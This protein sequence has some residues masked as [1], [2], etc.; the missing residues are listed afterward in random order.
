M[1]KNVIRRLGWI[2]MAT[3]ASVALAESHKLRVNDP[4]LAKSL[5][6]QGGR[7]VADYGSFQ[8][9][10]SDIVPPG[11]TG[12]QG[13]QLADDLNLI[14]L[15]A[16]VL[17]TRK[18]EIQASRR[19]V[20]PFSGKRLH[21]V[22]FAGPIRPEWVEALE[23][24]GV[25][26]ISYIPQDAYLIYGNAAALGRMQ[27][28]ARATSFVQWEGAY[29]PEYRIHPRAR[30][31]DRNRG[32]RNSGTDRFA[33][34]LVDDPDANPATLALIDRLKL[35]PVENQF[36][37]LR[38]LNVIV[39]L[40][41]EQLD[42]IAAQPEVVSIQP[43]L[44]RMKSDERQDQILAGNLSGGA[45]TGPGY[46]SWLASKG[47]TQEQFEESGFVVDLTDSGIDNGTN[48][49]GHFGLYK[50]GDPAEWSRIAYNRL[51]GS[52]NGG[53]TLQGCDGHGNLNAHIVGGYSAFTG[54]PFADSAGFD[55]GL[56][57]C[58]FVKIGSS[59]VFDPD[60]FTFPNYANL[61]SDAYHDGARVSANSWGAWYS[62][63]AYDIDA[64]RYD[65]LVRDA[66]PTN[67]T[68]AT[69]G[70]QQMVIVFAAGNQGPGAQT[71]QSPG[72][73]KNV[74]TVG[75]SESVRSLTPANGGN[76]SAGNDGCNTADSLADNA[77]DLA[78]YSG[79][80]PCSDGRMKPDIV[81]PGTHITGGVAQTSPPATNGTGSAIPC[82][83]ASE[84]ATLPG[85]GRCGTPAAGNTNNFFPLGQQFY[86]VSSGTSHATPAVAGVC[87]LVRQYFINHGLTPPSPAITKACLINSARY[88]NGANANDSLWSPSQGMGA[89]NLGTAFD[90]VPRIL[91][92]QVSGE[93]FTATGQTNLIT[94]TITD[95]TKPFRVT[96]AWTDAPG[97]TSGNAY[98]NDLDLTVTVGGNTYKGNVFAGAFTVAG[99]VY[100]K[101][102]N[103]ESV[104]LPAG[105]SGN[106]A[107]RIVAAN[108]NSDGVP[109]EAPSLD[110]DFALVVYNAT[111]APLPVLALDN[112]VVTAENCGSTNSAI[113]PDE[114]V[115][116]SF[117]L[118]NVG[119]VNTTNLVATLL[120]T[121]GVVWPSGPQSYGALA[122]NGG[123]VTQAFSFIAVGTC[124]GAVAPILQ[125]QEG[126]TTSGTV[127]AVFTM[128][129]PVVSTWTA[130]N[131]GNIQ[132]PASGFSG[133]ASPYP[134]SITISGLTGT[135]DKVTASLVGMTHTYSANVD[136]LL[137]GPTGTNVIL[138]SGCGQPNGVSGVTLT[139]DDTAASSLPQWG[140][141][142][143]GTYQP[144]DFNTGSLSFPSPAPM[145]P[146]GQ[147]LSVF[148][149]LN[150]NGTWSLYVQDQST[151]DAG[152]IAQGWRLSITTSNLV[153]C[154][155]APLPHPQFQS[156]S[157]S[158][159]VA[160]MTWTAIPGHTYRLQST[161]SLSANNWTN[162]PPDVTATNITA[163]RSDATNSANQNFYRVLMLP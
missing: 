74:I 108:I 112:S 40:A 155:G 49:P 120:P 56:G 142:I 10:E 30:V 54:F 149:G 62:A 115:T 39:R 4:A 13:S 131:A 70:N 15:N 59:V 26:I 134:S 22:H 143:S 9:L 147:T 95:P 16:R 91:H 50:H 57:V 138:M 117:V 25:Q 89:L 122:T 150:P 78:G 139:F 152:N 137:V 119:S 21:L 88:L 66:Q 76:D 96:L 69:A 148:N 140:Q 93:K 60:Y 101:Q 58:P 17:D 8:V 145:E 19:A 72:S 47:F 11:G 29:A 99:G 156:V 125:L 84:I 42:R 20:A 109:N 83:N 86:T 43:Y 52:P 71:V 53:S 128:G 28:W 38:Y 127:G 81:A 133:Q 6:A 77:Y 94:G 63:G 55:Y 114:T 97:S 111:E 68:F 136:V 141:I 105:L 90:G 104:F 151:Q 1:L 23:S 106:F 123:S 75:A 7:L 100:D 67:S 126:S 158:N 32:P 132:V 12:S 18:P 110:Q 154:S 130:T 3:I 157:L 121:N 79:R 163:A 44:D 135:V 37:T 51:E 116:V 103:V 98:N 129:A 160:T 80:G 85:A 144:T 159:G 24:N 87:A 14:Q 41:P 118:R 36:R 61:Q 45:P 92:D 48:V 35:A 162:L 2:F 33:V 5:I 107:V 73:A 82:F 153:C 31:T 124:G 113:D 102:N 65:A 146:F 46:L 161:P 34:Q 64:Q 27:S